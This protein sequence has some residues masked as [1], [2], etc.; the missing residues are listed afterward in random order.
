LKHCYK[1]VIIP[2]K[3]RLISFRIQH[4]RL[5]EQFFTHYTINS[6][7][8]RLES[9][10]LYG[11]SA[12]KL[13]SILVYFTSLLQL[14]ALTIELS[15]DN[16]PYNHLDEIYR[17][18]FRLPSLKYNSVILSQVNRLN[19][20]RGLPIHDRCITIKYLF[21]NHS[22]TVHDLTAVLSCT[23]QL[24]SLTCRNLI[25]SNDNVE[26]EVSITLPNLTYIYI[27][28]CYLAFDEFQKLMEK[29]CSQLKILRI[30]K[31]Y[32][33][34]YIGPERWQQLIL[35][36]MSQLRRFDL[37]CCMYLDNNFNDY[38]RD[39]FIHQFISEFWIERG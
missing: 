5:V 12:H 38:H 27:E 29:I 28:S 16:N 30:G 15:N 36:N 11:I 1:Q 21:M 7:F 6:S 26:S 20:F 17:S 25:E 23:P 19:A 35:D 4:P 3:H 8:N 14:F 39:S 34:L 2:N 9:I 32:S 22:C 33:R 13:I 24:S 31:F 10:T 18:I 37:K